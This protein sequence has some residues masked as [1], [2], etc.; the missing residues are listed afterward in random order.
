M[1]GDGGSGGNG[2]Q[3]TVNSNGEQITTAGNSSSGILAQSVGGGGGTGG[4]SIALS[5]GVEAAVVAPL[6]L[7]LWRQGWERR[8]RRD[9]DG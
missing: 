4:G 6:S 2:G 8:Q 1:G 9:R 3:V 5:I 7:S